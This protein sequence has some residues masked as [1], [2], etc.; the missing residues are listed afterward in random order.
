MYK[1][2][3]GHDDATVK[4]SNC[5]LHQIEV[6]TETGTDTGNVKSKKCNLCHPDPAVDSNIFN[7]CY[8]CEKCLSQL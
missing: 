3:V 7:E 1:N 4:A 6:H 2:E 5:Q 8:F